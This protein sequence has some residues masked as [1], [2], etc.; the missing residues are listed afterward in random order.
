M[1]EM[2]FLPIT[3]SADKTSVERILLNEDSMKF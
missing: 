1:G 2:I 3:E